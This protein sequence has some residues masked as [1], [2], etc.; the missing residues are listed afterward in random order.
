MISHRRLQ[1]SSAASMPVIVVLNEAEVATR[2]DR[3]LSMD[4]S[5]RQGCLVREP[6][7]GVEVGS[8]L[9]P[10]GAACCWACSGH[11][12]RRNRAGARTLHA[13]LVVGLALGVPACQTRAA[14]T[15]AWRVKKYS[16]RKLRP[17]T[18]AP[19]HR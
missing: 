19:W 2:G 18:P 6:E 5:C 10:T 13:A 17:S 12:H 14:T 9:R 15:P 4:L 3:T 7:S 8:D 16:P 11:V 1:A